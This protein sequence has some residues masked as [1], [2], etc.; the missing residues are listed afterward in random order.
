[1]CQCVNSKLS[2]IN[3]RLQDIA[4]SH[5]KNKFMG[6]KSFIASGDLWQLPPIYDTMVTDRNN[7]D[8]R[9]VCAPSHW[10]ENFRIFYLTEKM[11][12]L[13][14]MHFSS[15]CDRVA[16]GTFN[17]NDE[18]F[19]LDPNN[20]LSWYLTCDTFSKVHISY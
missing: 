16:R 1:M 6:G 14:D 7:L 5:N 20:C 18:N 11:R 10:N 8:G 17:E 19:I 4:E 2:K 12:C 3:F 13:N 15:L 9:P